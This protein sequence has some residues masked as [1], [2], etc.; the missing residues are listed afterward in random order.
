MLFGRDYVLYHLSNEDV[1][2]GD[3]SFTGNTRKILSGVK[4]VDGYDDGAMFLMNDNTLYKYR[5]H[6]LGFEKISTIVL[7]SSVAHKTIKQIYCKSHNAGIIFTDKTICLWGTSYTQLGIDTKYMNTISLWDN[8]EGKAIQLALSDNYILAL[9]VFD[10][11]DDRSVC[12]DIYFCGSDYNLD[13]RVSC[14]NRKPKLIMIGY[15]LKGKVRSIECGKECS[16]CITVD[17]DIYMWRMNRDGELGHSM[18]CYKPNWSPR[19]IIFSHSLSPPKCLLMSCGFNH[20]A[21]IF[22]KTEDGYSW[23]SVKTW[24]YNSQALDIC[25]GGWK[26]QE[27]TE[28]RDDKIRQH[29]DNL[30][31]TMLE[32]YETRVK[33]FTGNGITAIISDESDQ[34]SSLQRLEDRNE[35]ESSKIDEKMELLKYFKMI[36]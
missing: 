18:G 11:K 26:A 5:I 31:Y 9:V 28:I 4:Q 13:H 12:G 3:G 8:K 14:Y 36:L 6:M 25:S 1:Y 2:L 35:F 17:Y 21:A 7:P 20:T 30:N 19:R 10:D 24:G 15:K 16:A 33:I 23:Y 27:P 22:K 32:K 29:L 34:V